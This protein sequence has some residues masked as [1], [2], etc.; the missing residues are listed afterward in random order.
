LG[1]S[2]FHAL[3]PVPVI[4]PRRIVST[5]ASFIEASRACAFV[6]AAMRRTR[7]SGPFDL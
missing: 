2:S 1:R 4:S 5:R 3:F 7:V 6:T